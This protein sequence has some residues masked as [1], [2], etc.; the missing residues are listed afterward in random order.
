MARAV[1]SSSAGRRLD[2]ELVAKAV[3][4]P[5]H[6]RVAADE[7]VAGQAVALVAEHGRRRGSGPSAGGMWQRLAAAPLLEERAV[8]PLLV[9]HLLGQRADDPAVADRSAS[10]ISVWH[11]AQSSDWRTCGASTCSK[12]VDRSHDLL[13]AGVHGERPEDRRAC[14]RPRV[15]RTT[16]LPLK[17]PRVP[18]PSG[19][20]W[21]QT[22]QETPSLPG[23]VGSPVVAVPAIAQVREDVAV[24]SGRVRCLL[25]DRHVAGG[26]LVLDLAARVG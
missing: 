14:R 9:V 11:V 21:W 10:V 25:R 24:P 16:K 3:H 26:A 1:A 18:R 20:I 2:A 5:E 12:P 17:M 19:A 8:L 22:V 6:E 7:R 4:Q 15:G 13:P 23:D